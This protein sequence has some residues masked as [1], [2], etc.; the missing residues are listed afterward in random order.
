VKAK[1]AVLEAK[2]WQGRR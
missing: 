2:V 1:I